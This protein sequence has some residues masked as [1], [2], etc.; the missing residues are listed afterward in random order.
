MRS[1]VLIGVVFALAGLCIGSLDANRLDGHHWK[2]FKSRYS[3][4]YADPSEESMRRSIFLENKQKIDR[5][6]AELASSL[7]Y[8][9]GYSH[10]SDWTP[11]ELQQLNGLKP[12]GERFNVATDQDDM[13]EF[14]REIFEMD[15]KDLPKEVDWRKVPGRVGPVKDQGHCGS[16]WAFATTGVLEGQQY[17]FNMSEVVP[18]SEQNLIDCSKSDLG[19]K[20]GIMSHALLDIAKEHGIESEKDYPYLD[21]KGPVEHKC[22]FNRS[23]SVMNIRGIR[24]VPFPYENHLKKAVAKVGP[25]A[26]GVYVPPELVHYKSGVFYYDEYSDQDPNHGVL[27]VGYG[28]NSEDDD[29]WI[30]VS[31]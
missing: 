21:L 14:L 5:H 18:L 10:L 22:T 17:R 19:C 2:Q 20:G 8:Q 16:C 9:M 4:V 30:V 25:I 11:E 27:I 13:P 29:Y 24:M 7:G 28:T 23:Q 12:E 26:S 31:T 1:L 6:N 15:D 3:K